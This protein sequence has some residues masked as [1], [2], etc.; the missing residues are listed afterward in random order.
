M[1]LDQRI[2]N[3]TSLNLYVLLKDNVELL[4]QN[5]GEIEQELEVEQKLNP[6][7]KLKALKPPRKFFVNKE[8][9]SH[10]LAYN[11]SY[12]EDLIR[13][14][15]E[16]LSAVEKDIAKEI[17]YSLDEKGFISE[18]ALNQIKEY[19]NV[20]WGLVEDA[21]A[22]VMEIE[23]IG[24]GSLN[25][26][27]YMELQI[28]AYYKDKKDY[29]KYLKDPSSI[30]NMPKEALEF[31][32]KL[33]KSPAGVD[34]SNYIPSKVDAVIEIDQREISYDIYD[35]YLECNIDDTALD[36][37]DKTLRTYLKQRARNYVEAINLRKR[38]LKDIIGLIVEKQKDFFLEDKPL[39]S[40]LLKD[41][42][43]TFGMSISTVSRLLNS[44][45]A[46]T[47]KGIFRLRSFLSR[48]SV[49]YKSQDEILSLIKKLIQNEETVYT[50]K[51]IEEILRNYGI[52]ISRRTVAKYRAKLGIGSSRKR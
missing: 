35:N 24:Y 5:V 28:R 21:R 27:E 23:P 4:Q 52:N 45:Y 15:D 37:E 10:L 38:L 20:D 30:K 3:R 6:F 31:F 34:K 44:K 11:P 42:S 1:N 26:F 12:K 41:I 8:D 43:N 14:I 50:D 13:V 36:I 29:I 9:F 7:F 51:D 46:K 40:L 32:S 49:S 25:T 2:E 33:K 17:V 19:F 16:E 39:K 18:E 48:E 47:P 22:F